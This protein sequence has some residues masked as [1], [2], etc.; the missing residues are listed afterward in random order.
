DAD[1]AAALFC[2]PSSRRPSARCAAAIDALLAAKALAPF[3]S[4][5]LLALAEAY[6]AGGEPDKADRQLEAALEL[7]PMA[8]GVRVQRAALLLE[9]GE[10]ALALDF[11]DESTEKLPQEG[12]LWVLKAVA[13]HAGG[14]A[15][16]ARG[17]RDPEAR[18]LYGVLLQQEGR[19]EQAIAQYE[20][21]L[22]EAGEF[23]QANLNLGLALFAQQKYEDAAAR[24]QRVLDFDE[25]NTVAHLQLALLCKDYL[26]EPERA[27]EHLERYAA[28]GGPDPRA[29]EWLD[30]L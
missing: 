5:P 27:R 10:H 9:R 7:E 1:C 2:S 29:A 24:F 11:L 13:L 28:L 6:L 12:R 22:S 21:V 4:A 14:D 18:C 26:D 23:P 19:L 25:T 20:L 17:V 8:G 15:P 16:S 3:S 30:E